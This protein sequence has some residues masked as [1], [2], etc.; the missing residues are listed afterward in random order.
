VPAELRRL[1]LRHRVLLRMEREYFTNHEP[2]AV[3]C[4]SARE[5]QDLSEIYGVDRAVMHVLPNPFDGASFSVERRNSLRDEMRAEIGAEP[6]D[7]VVLIVANEWHRKGLGALLAAVA[8]VG[9]PRLRLDL[10]GK[11]PPDDYRPI[12]A[13]LGLEDRFHWHGPSSDVARYY[14]CADIFALPTTYEPFGLVIVEAMASGLPVITSAL[15][16]AAELIHH[17]TSGFVLID[18]AD[19]NEIARA[20]TELLDPVRRNVVGAAA[21][22][23]AESCEVK[24][25]MAAADRL[26]FPN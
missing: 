26:I 20:I 12:A 21:A 22:L 7:V 4:T 1:L 25:V 3:L 6:E 11:R 13:R 16:G 19:E 5:V 8:Q 10:V 2:R 14:A 18:P 9:D 15:A 24:T 23:A 17:G